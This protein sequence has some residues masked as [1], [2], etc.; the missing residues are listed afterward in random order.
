MADAM[1]N[2]LSLLRSL[3]KIV[4]QATELRLHSSRQ[5][6]TLDANGAATYLSPTIL[7]NDYL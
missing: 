1:G 5:K 6:R 4:L 3:T 7:T 2:S